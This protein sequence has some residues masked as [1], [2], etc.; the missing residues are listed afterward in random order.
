VLGGDI[1]LAAQGI[2]IHT[3]DD[4]IAA[5]RAIRDRPPGREVR[6]R[7]L[8]GGKVVDL[9]T[10]WAGGSPEGGVAKP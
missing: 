1:I 10:T 6:M 8:R 9:T 7:V 5:A 4:L 3:I 2:E